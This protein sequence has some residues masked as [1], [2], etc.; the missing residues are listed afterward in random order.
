MDSKIDFVVKGTKSSAE[1]TIRNQSDLIMKLEKKYFNTWKKKAGGKNNTPRSEKIDE[2]QI[3]ELGEHIQFNYSKPMWQRFE[4]KVWT[5]F[6]DVG[7]SDEMILPIG[8]TIV[9]YDGSNTKQIDGLFSDSEYVYVVECKFRISKGGK[10][11]S[12]GN[13]VDDMK[14]WVGIWKPLCKKLSQINE[15]KGKKPVF[16]LATQGVEWNDKLRKTIDQIDGILIDDSQIRGLIGLTDN[17]ASGS[18]IAM[19]RQELFRESKNH[20][21][22]PGV[23]KTFPATKT[24]V[25][26][27]NM[28][29]FFAKSEDLI[30]LAHVPRRMP[31]GG[32][33]SKAYQR[34]M[35]PKKIQAIGRY[36][37][38]KG[39]YFPNS[40]VAASEFTPTWYMSDKGEFSESGKI[41]L[42]N[43]YG[44]L[45]IIDGQHRLFG[46]E[47]SNEE[48][49]KN[50]PLSIC[51]IEGLSDT[52]QA[53][54][55]TTINQEQTKVD[56]DLLWDLY[57]ELG[58]VDPPPDLENKSEVKQATMYVIS[59]VW[60]RINQSENHPM[61]GTIKVPSHP[62]SSRTKISFGN[63]L[64]K[65]L[66]QKKGNW[67]SG[68]L[69]PSSWTRAENYAYNR[70]S[71]FYKSLLTN[72]DEEWE[73]PDS[74][75]D[76]NWL[77]SNYS[78]I[79]ITQVFNHMVAH[80]GGNARFK[81][82]WRKSEGYKKLV[83][84]FTNIL[85]KAIMSP[86]HGFFNVQEKRNI[87]KQG[88]A[89][90]RGDYA[91]DLVLYIKENGGENTKIS[92]RILQ[93]RK[94]PIILHKKPKSELKMLKIGS[95]C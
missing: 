50:K 17:Y 22:I 75:K 45:F 53:Q 62:S 84:E 44:S 36:L 72:L 27:N 87:L 14:K 16:I 78:M 55:F 5:M 64:C 73:K 38:E 42:I 43:K 26:G 3:V 21:Q 13:I 58:T 1:Y 90:G 18:T 63:T 19:F 39:S 81:S 34:S 65:Y 32:D 70:V 20:R 80:F 29:H 95:E 12:P 66:L 57:G 24:V 71:Y 56:P 88:G 68:Y 86:E 4:D 51:L 61:C 93:K 85:S 41:E 91:R 94:R 31:T 6:H 2:E 35:K 59:K 46:T 40:I 79:V 89:A 9:N 82:E 15:F 48:T 52:N 10:N 74:K 83:D 28:F 69:R 67:E 47:G 33:L 60:K 49:K 23:S 54:L 7:A 76:K 37:S 8:D 25:D 77:C 11:I 92:P 30:E